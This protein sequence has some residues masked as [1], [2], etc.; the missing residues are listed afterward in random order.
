MDL[1]TYIYQNAQAVYEKN[2][3]YGWSM[4][5]TVKS[6]IEN[7]QRISRVLEDIES[8]FRGAELVASRGFYGSG[9]IKVMKLPERL[10]YKPIFMEFSEGKGKYF[11]Q[12]LDKNSDFLTLTTRDLDDLEN[13]N[14]V[15]YHFDHTSLYFKL[16]THV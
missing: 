7:Y 10:K 13:G 15:S 1:E 4:T 3:T 12:G 2:R 14:E 16:K 9:G 6:V 8:D 11:V 5:K